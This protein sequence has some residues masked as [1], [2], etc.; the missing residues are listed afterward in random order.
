[1]Q[2][3]TMRKRYGDSGHPCLIPVCCVWV[4]EYCPSMQTLNVGF[5]YSVFIMLISFSG[6]CNLFNDLN[7]ASWVSLSKAF[8]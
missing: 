6:S 8:S 2:D 5:L 3:M 4:S 1:M 7:R